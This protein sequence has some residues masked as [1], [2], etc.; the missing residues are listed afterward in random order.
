VAGL[1][2]YQPTAILGYPSAL[3]LLAEE[4][5]AGRLRV[6]PRRFLSA[7]ELL[8]PEVRRVVEETLRGADRQHVAL[9][10]GPRGRPARAAGRRQGP[11]VPADSRLT[12]AKHGGNG[13]AKPRC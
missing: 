11:Q 10:R 7:A 3:A 9:R 13:S 6:A 8:L 4:A 1:N 5:R 2:A 12:G